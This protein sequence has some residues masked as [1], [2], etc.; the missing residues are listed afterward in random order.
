MRIE[1][2][3]S[4]GILLLGIIAAGFYW[5][6]LELPDNKTDS[7]P[8][9]ER[10]ILP[11][12]SANMYQQIPEVQRYLT[13]LKHAIQN[14]QSVL[15]LEDSELDS[16]AKIAQTLLLT[17][18]QFLQDTTRGDKI[19][20]NDMMSIRPAII[21]VLNAD[22]QVVCQ[23]HTCYQAEKYNYVTNSTT[24]AI[25]DVDD[26]AVL[27]VQNYSNMQ[28]DISLRLTRIAQQIAIN[29]PEVIKEL[30]YTPAI[31]DM[32]MANVRA[33]LKESPCENS[34]HLCVAPTF[35]DHQNQEALWA[36]V[37]LTDLKLAAAK[38]AGLGK[39]T[40]P[41]C[42]SERSLQ[43]RVIMKNYCQKETV[44]EKNGWQFDYRLTGSDG[45]EIRNAS[46]QGDMVFTSAKI[47][48]WHVSYQQKKGVT[49][50]TTVEAYIEGR[51]VEF[52]RDDDDNYFF[53]YNDAMGCP[54]FST[55]VVLPF[56]GPQTRDLTDS[57]DQT[58]GF[59]ITQDFRNPKWPMACNYR[60]ENRFEF[61]NDGSFRVVGGNKGRG[62]GDNAIYRPV[63]RIDMAIDEK[64]TFYQYNQQQWQQ[65]NQEQQHIYSKE[66]VYLENKYLYKITA[67]NND[68]QGYYIEPNRGQFSDSS[69]GDFATLFA[70]LFKP[71]EGDQDLLTLGSCCNLKQEGV[72]PFQDPVESI[73]GENI[74]IWYVP[75]IQNDTTE[76]NEYCWADTVIGNNG[77]LEV[78]EWPCYVGPKFVPIVQ[79]ATG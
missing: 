39:T 70:T 24:R 64:E 72:E 52:N 9:E 12:Y 27:S 6:E 18:H 69:R 34:A 74:I 61:Y 66:S 37:D 76:G 68:Q 20:H 54:M 15:P 30:K 59:Y 49:L 47:V 50:D 55:S 4:I 22:Q 51:R 56:N 45:L 41:A 26:K 14:G 62:C 10:V 58:T 25:V 28:P 32:S 73:D 19:L 2:K 53:G 11:K 48:D 43:N 57:N 29:A 13:D 75:R 63:M 46:F 65:W 5:F 38:W 23:K 78:K 60:Y 16:G 8:I 17:N 31:K 71:E 67:Q 44:L 1:T 40:T 77:N 21:S 7:Q 36:I 79:D 42:I 35:A 33:A 3:I